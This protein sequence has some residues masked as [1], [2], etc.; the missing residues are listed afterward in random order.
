MMQLTFKVR[1]EKILNLV[2]KLSIR[3]GMHNQFFSILNASLNNK[4]IDCKN[5]NY[6]DLFH[7]S[8]LHHV[9]SLVYN[10]I[11][12]NNDIPVD[13]KI[14]WRNNLLTTV[15]MQNLRSQVFLGVYKELINE[16]LKVVV[17]KGIILRSLYPEP[18]FRPSNDEDIYI[19]KH[20]LKQILEI[21]IKNQFHIVKE[22]DDVIIV[23]HE[24][25]GLCVEIHT[26]LFDSEVDNFNKYQ[27]YFNNKFDDLFKF[28]IDGYEV[29]SFSHSEHF[30]F[31]SL[32]LI[33]HI[34]HSGVG[35]R[36]V[37]D[38]YMYY[39]YYASDIDFNYIYKI[40][41]DMGLDFVMN[42]IF[43]FLK[44]Y[45]DLDDQYIIKY[46][47]YT[48][49]YAELINDILES[50]LYGKTS[51][52]RIH[53]GNMTISSFS[54]NNI[55]K[56]SLFPSLKIMKDRYSYLNQYPSLI[57]LAW[58]S[59]IFG[60]LFNKKSGNKKETVELGNKRIKLLKKYKVI[61]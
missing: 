35:I 13:L 27:T 49:E 57:V 40:Y 18:D 29:Y 5:I 45:F 8:N 58:I 61:Q 38:I 34:L 6:Y 52:E 2:P 37:M 3:A 19:Q 10:T 48:L 43:S 4:K 53:S 36:Q 56:G 39:R 7:L 26:S 30:L 55:L 12:Q 46:Y 31:L 24:Y 28:T 21:F 1:K 25:S 41:N 14:N 42:N 9:S 11:H 22:K 60:Y 20:D 59:R 50:G 54:S 32:H 47:H 15:G 44:D 17:V 33:K 51:L 16:G 23:Y